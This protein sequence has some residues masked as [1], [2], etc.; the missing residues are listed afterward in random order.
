MADADAVRRIAGTLPEV[1]VG[2]ERSGQL[3]VAF[4]DKLIAWSWLERDGAR[5][6]RHPNPDVL[7]VRVVSN[8]EKDEL[9]LAEP[10]VFFTE[11][12]Y[13]G[14]PAVL[15]RLAAIEEDELRELLTDAWRLRA[16]K[17]LQ[18]ATGL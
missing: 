5:G 11:R 8:L 12:H 16:P 4:R 18:K 7:G 9:I 3:R 14:Y 13:D 17:R 6:R 1:T 10:E 2:Q 15:V